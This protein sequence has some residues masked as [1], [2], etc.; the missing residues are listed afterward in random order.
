[1]K[2]IFGIT[3]D[4]DRV[5]RMMDRLDDPDNREVKENNL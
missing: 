3:I 2:R 4:L 5:Y 1:L